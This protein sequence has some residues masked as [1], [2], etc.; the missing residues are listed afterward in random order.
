MSL[1]N[2]PDVPNLPGVPAINRS[3]AGYVAAGLTILGEIL[4]LST[5]GL[6]WG[7]TFLDGTSALTPDSFVSYE[8]KEEYRIP[9]YPTELGGFLNYNKV[10]LPFDIKITV[11][12]SGNG[13]M[14]TTEFLQRLYY[15][16][17]TTTFIS[18]ITPD[19]SFLVTNLIHIDY[20][21]EATNGATMIIANLWFQEIR[22]TEELLPPT[23]Q[24]QGAF[25]KAMG[26]LSAFSSKVTDSI[27]SIF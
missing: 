5:F 27:T 4:P 8:Y 17:E 18:I 3:S 19:I 16:L 2:Y 20:K 22:L 24:P 23:A 12:C 21:K 13:K 1:I 15:L 11:T 7:I 9:N 14:T 26:Q 6:N 10:A 25:A